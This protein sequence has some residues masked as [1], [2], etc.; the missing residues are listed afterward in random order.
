MLLQIV[1]GCAERQLFIEQSI[2]HRTKKHNTYLNVWTYTQWTRRTP[3]HILIII[4][5][6][7]GGSSLHIILDCGIFRCGYFWF[8][9]CIQWTLTPLLNATFSPVLQ[10]HGVSTKIIKSFSWWFLITWYVYSS[11]Q[12]QKQVY[13]PNH[14]ELFQ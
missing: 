13:K 12:E 9:Y 14:G 5:S 1:F 2:I 11:E 3:T 4:S 8:P 10:S 7:C 6:P